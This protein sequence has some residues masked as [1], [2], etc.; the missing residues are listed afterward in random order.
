LLENHPVETQKHQHLELTPL[1]ASDH[2]PDE[3][4]QLSLVH[5]KPPVHKG[6]LAE[7]KEEMAKTA[8][9]SLCCGE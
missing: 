1:L 2:I 6:L 7:Q 8:I 5:R 3:Q 9:Q 4:T